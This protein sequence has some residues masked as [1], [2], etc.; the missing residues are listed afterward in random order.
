MPFRER[1]RQLLREPLVQFLIG[2][3]LIFVF[4]LWRGEEVDPASRTIDVTPEIQAQIALDYERTMQRLPTDRELDGLIGQW[5][6]EEV[7]YREALRLGFDAN[8]PVVR[9][10]LAKK[11]EFLAASSAETAEP[12]DT[13]LDRW[14]RDNAA[15]YAPDVRLSFDQV[16]FPARPEPA[17][18]LPRLAQDWRSVGEPSSL[19]S[20]IELREKALVAAEFGA[21]FADRLAAMKPGSGWQGP[22][23]SG[24]GWHFVRLREVVPGRVPPLAD[25]RERVLADWR[26]AT[27]RQREEAAYRVLRDAYTVKIAR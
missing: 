24:V 25:V 21:A 4:F 23:A 26:L 27:A 7:L 18:A 3:A 9:R 15:R 19:P 10:R 14:Y 11:M 16:Y 8:D 6:R 22:V 5:V 2:G 13:E 12:T 20:Q 1:A 17:T